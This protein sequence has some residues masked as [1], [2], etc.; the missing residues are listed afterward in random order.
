MPCFRTKERLKIGFVSG[1]YLSRFQRPI[2][3]IPGLTA[4]PIWKP[5]DVGDKIYKSLELIRQVK[6]EWWLRQFPDLGNVFFTD[7]EIFVYLCLLGRTGRLSGTKVW[8]CWRRT[9]VGAWTRAGGGCRGPGTQLSHARNLE[10]QEHPKIVIR[11]IRNIMSRR[12]NNKPVGSR[13]YT[14]NL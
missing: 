10:L 2:S 12:N 11:K 1:I 5:K 7:S 13:T 8:S 9:E 14:G 6:F 3:A 4:K